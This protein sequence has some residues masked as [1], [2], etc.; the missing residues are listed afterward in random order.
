MKLLKNK[1]FFIFIVGFNFLF[2]RQAAAQLTVAGGLTPTQLVQ[3]VLIGSGI[4]VNNVVY[5]GA[6]TAIGT[7]NGTASNIGLSYG[8]IMTSGDRTVAP[9]PNTQSGAGYDNN[10]SGDASLDLLTTSSTYDAAVLE[11]DFIPISNTVSVR[12]VTPEFY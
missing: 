5:T 6:D 10:Q 7:F 11:F 4:T 12:Y 8:V 1:I 2:I 9:G 3:N